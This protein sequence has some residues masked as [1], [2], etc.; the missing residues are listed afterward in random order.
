MIGPRVLPLAALALALVLAG[1]AG[2]SESGSASANTTS[3]PPTTS[4]DGGGSTGS[5]AAFTLAG[6]SL[7]GPTPRPEGAFYEDDNVTAHYEVGLRGDYRGSATALVSF[8][9]DNKVVDVT[10][11]TL[12]SGEVRKYDRPLSLLNRT[13]VHVLVKM[14]AAQS[15]VNATVLKWPRVGETVTLGNATLR[16]ASWTNGTSG[17]HV[18]GDAT[19]ATGLAIRLHLLCRNGASVT[20]AGEPQTVTLAGPFALDFGA[21]ASPYGIGASADDVDG[22]T[23]RAR[24]LFAR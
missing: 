19:P 2:K 17:V 5:D 4:V 6:P 13:A 8:L 23:V 7:V 11:V 21:C 10:S 14:G 15:S 3:T 1:C 20:E 9:V 16:L 18:E 24:I 22:S 12:K